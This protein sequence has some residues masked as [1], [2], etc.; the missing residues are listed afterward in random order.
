MKL[1]S[2]S[3]LIASNSNEIKLSISC[4]SE[5]FVSFSTTLDE[6]LKYMSG[7]SKFVSTNSFLIPERE[8]QNFACF[9]SYHL[10]IDRI[11][12]PR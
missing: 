9:S 4:K 1:L 3:E 12:V 7:Y 8:T 10:A 6:I 2:E 11:Y 5:N